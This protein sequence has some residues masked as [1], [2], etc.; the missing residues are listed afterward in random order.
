MITSR[1][2]LTFAFAF[3][4]ALAPAVCTADVDFDS[5]RV[6]W[7][8]VTYHEMYVYLD[9]SHDICIVTRV[10]DKYEIDILQFD[11]VDF[12]DLSS[13]EL[14]FGLSLYGFDGLADLASDVEHHEFDIEADEIQAMAISASGGNDI[15][16][17]TEADCLCHVSGGTG[18]DI[19]WGVDVESET[20]LNYLHGDKGNDDLYGGR[21]PD[22]LCGGRGHDSLRGYEGPDSLNGDD[23]NDYL[24]GGPGDDVLNGSGG[25]DT[26]RGNE[27]NDII[28]GSSGDDELLGGDGEDEIHGGDGNDYLDGGYDGAMDT[29]IGDE[30]ADDFMFRRYR[31][32]ELK[33]KTLSSTDPRLSSTSTRQ[34][35]TSTVQYE[36]FTVEMDVVDDY[37]YGD[38]LLS[39]RV[40]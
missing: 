5:N 39:Q 35:T 29:L 37:E 15:I 27:D 12:A 1:I 38:A 20:T 26:I 33:M 21:G 11:E 40:N 18:D 6:E 17:L 9:T 14:N 3:L 19:I 7:E 13:W 4:I 34:T 2:Q 16:I 32:V 31:L 36:Q 22:Q 23:G 8:G 28:Y 24:Y 10:D 25:D 30:G